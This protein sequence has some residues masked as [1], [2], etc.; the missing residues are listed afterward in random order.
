MAERGAGQPDAQDFHDERQ[1]RA[2]HAADRG[3]AA[4][5]RR[6]RVGGGIAVPVHRP[7]RRYGFSFLRVE[8]DLA[9]HDF[10]E[11]QVHHDRIG[12]PARE[13]RGDGIGAEERLLPAP[14]VDRRRR[15]GEREPDQPRLRER[16]KVIGC[17]AEMVAVGDAG[18]CDAVALRALHRLLH[19]HR[20]RDVSEPARRVDQAGG[21][22]LP[23]DSGFRLARYPAF[24]EVL[25]VQRDARQPVPGEPFHLR[26]HQRPCGRF[27]R[28]PGR[29]RPLQRAHRELHCIVNGQFGHD[30]RTGKTLNRQDLHDLQD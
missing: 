3:E 18:E 10:R 28:G 8:H 13:D 14:G 1:H 17:R 20:A 21:A 5:Q 9:A 23:D 11:R 2:F 4:G 22:L 6:S 7:A 30:A 29:A 15:I 27:G 16:R 26:G 19:R 25:H 12:V 24:L